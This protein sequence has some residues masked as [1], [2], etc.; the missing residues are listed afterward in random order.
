MLK[1]IFQTEKTLDSNFKPYEEM[2]NIAK[3]KLHLLI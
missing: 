2:K 1:E 3:G